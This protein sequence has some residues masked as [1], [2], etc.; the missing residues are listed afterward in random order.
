[1]STNFKIYLLPDHISRN[2]DN[3]NCNEFCTQNPLK[4]RELTYGIDPNNT[5]Y[6]NVLLE[7]IK[8]LKSNL[9]NWYDRTTYEGLCITKAQP[10]VEWFVGAKC[11]KYASNSKWVLFFT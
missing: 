3:E 1:V 4:A 11:W 5:N 7:H 9:T 10:T 2:E 8:C 6:K